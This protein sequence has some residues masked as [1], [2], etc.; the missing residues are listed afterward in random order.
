MSQVELLERAGFTDVAEIDLTQ[1]F[2]DTTL[3]WPKERTLRADEV[4]AAEGEER[5]LERLSD[6]RAQADGIRDGLLRRARYVA[7][8]S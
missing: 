8:D 2:L 4:K 1:E 6:C 7:R 5:F 3:A